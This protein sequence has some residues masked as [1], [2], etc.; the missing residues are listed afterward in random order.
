MTK[1]INQ[2]KVVLAEKKRTNKWLA[3]Q[4]SKVPATVSKWCTNTIQ[5]SLETLIEIAKCLDVKVQDL[6]RDSI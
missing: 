1:D 5:S 6:L 2:L 4:L 3:E